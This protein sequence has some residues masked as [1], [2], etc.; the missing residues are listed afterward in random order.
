MGGGDARWMPPRLRTL[1]PKHARPALRVC[2]ALP[3]TSQAAARATRWA[4]RSWRRGR[5]RSIT[6][7]G[8]GRPARVPVALRQPSLHFRR[9]ALTARAAATSAFGR[10]CRNAS[11]PCRCWPTLPW[12][13]PTAVGAYCAR[14]VFELAGADGVRD[15]EVS[16]AAVEVSWAAGAA[17][18]AARLLAPSFPACSLVPPCPGTCTVMGLRCQLTLFCLPPT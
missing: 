6:A 7:V 8:G 14:R 4:Q 12:R 17:A 13:A 9:R 15:P 3:C 11:K 18:R 2:A 16:F 10:C 1:H 5:R